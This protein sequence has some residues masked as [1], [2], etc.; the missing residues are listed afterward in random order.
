[1]TWLLDGSVL[2]A[3]TVSDHEFNDRCTDWFALQ[4]RGQERFATCP[5]TEGTLLRL[6]MQLESDRS[7]Q[8]AWEK[9]GQVRNLPSHEFWADNF[10]YFEIDYH[11]IQGH[12]QV[13]D[14]WLV[15]LAHRRK[16]RL[17]TLDAALATLHPDVVELVPVIL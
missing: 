10:S 1:M 6:H 17:A 15:A 14:A 2:I 7:A 11:L 8:S 4:I 13:T 16:G 5:L 12:R 9:L 3:L